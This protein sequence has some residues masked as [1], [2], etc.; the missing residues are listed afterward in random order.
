MKIDPNK[1]Q[2]EEISSKP[3][4]KKK[5]VKECKICF[6][7]FVEQE[8]AFSV[9]FEL[10]SMYKRSPIDCFDLTYK[11]S[12]V[13]I[14]PKKETTVCLPGDILYHM[15]SLKSRF[16]EI[17]T[18]INEI[19]NDSPSRSEY[20]D[21]YK[22]KPTSI[23]DLVQSL[24]A[25]LEQED[26]EIIEICLNRNSRLYEL[27]RAAKHLEQYSKEASS[28]L[29]IL[30]PCIEV[31][32]ASMPVFQPLEYIQMLGNKET[33]TQIQKIKVLNVDI[34]TFITVGYYGNLMK[35]V[36]QGKNIALMFESQKGQNKLFSYEIKP[37]E[38]STYG[39]SDFSSMQKSDLISKKHF[40]IEFAE[41]G[42]SFILTDEGSTNGICVIL[43]SKVNQ[44]VLMKGFPYR[45]VSNL[46]FKKTSIEVLKD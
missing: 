12:G 29:E 17:E 43:Y 31:A 40:S 7:D 19:L 46:N 10:G 45:V 23:K 16:G 13:I 15:V 36:S 21:P 3:I 22:I 34:P 1:N 5:K 20:I 33:R 30:K 6:S 4:E 27:S 35:I 8:D 42:K 9:K 18:L 14:S 2:I 11:E 37:G 24:K 28:I 38:T 41:D 26:D 32:R 39:K 44:I 25:D